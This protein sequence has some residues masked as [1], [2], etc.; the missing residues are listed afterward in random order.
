[1]PRIAPEPLLDDLARMAGSSLIGPFG[2]PPA[3]QKKTRPSRRPDRWRRVRSRT[4]LGQTVPNDWKRNKVKE[5]PLAGRP[6][7]RTKKP[8]PSH[9]S[10]H[11]RQRSSSSS[12]RL[13]RP[14][15]TSRNP[16]R[17]TSKATSLARDV[18]PAGS[19]TAVEAATINPSPRRYR[20]GR[21]V[22]ATWREETDRSYTARLPGEWSGTGW[23]WAFPVQWI[24]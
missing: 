4:R 2:N 13:R 15:W 16:Q 21:F 5:K 24:F 12:P 23:S 6:G 19:R 17:I 1:M 10:R 14:M 3:L 8:V 9:F 20:P 18:R 7:D 22:A 11:F